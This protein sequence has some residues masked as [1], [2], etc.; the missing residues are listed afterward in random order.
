MGET[1]GNHRR[2]FSMRSTGAASPLSRAPGGRR[3]TAK[4][5]ARLLVA[6]MAV[7]VLALAN[8]AGTELAQ[9]Q[10]NT[11]TD[12][13]AL[14]A[15]YNATDGPITGGAKINW[16]SDRPL[17]EWH[18]VRTAGNGPVTGLDL[19]HNQLSGEIPPELG[20]LSNLRWLEL[21][22]NQVTGPV[23]TRLRL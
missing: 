16:L 11:S 13:V 2:I 20:S 15:L 22:G 14:V 18:G 10:T 8:T 9:A 21:Q 12:R 19:S 1:N 5:I 7:A 17:G 3:G 4:S 23:P 6:V